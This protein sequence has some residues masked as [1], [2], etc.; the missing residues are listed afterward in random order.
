MSFS[1]SYWSLV[2][3]ARTSILALFLGLC[4]SSANADFSITDSL[5]ALPDGTFVFSS[6]ATTETFR[7]GLFLDQKMGNGTVHTSDQT[8]D[9]TTK[10]SDGF[11]KS[12]EGQ[13]VFEGTLQTAESGETL[14]FRETFVKTGAESATLTVSVHASKP[15][16]QKALCLNFLFGKEFR[17]RTFLFDGEPVVVP[18]KVD[19]PCLFFTPH[20]KGVS[21]IVI[22]GATQMLTL[23]GGAFDVLF[24]QY[25]NGQVSLRL[26]LVPAN[27]EVTDGELRVELSAAP[28]MTTPVDIRAAAN[29][30]FHDETA[31]DER[32][33]WTDQGPKNDLRVLPVGKRS[34]GNVPFNI[35]DASENSGRSCLVLGLNRQNLPKSAEIPL[36]GQKFSYLYLLHASAWTPRGTGILCGTVAVDYDDGS[37]Q[38]FDVQSGR[39]IGDWWD[40]VSGQNSA[41]VWKDKNAGGLTVGLYLSRFRVKE[42][43]ISRITLTPAGDSVWM[44][45]G[46]SGVKEGII[47]AMPND[48]DVP[49]TIVMREDDDWKSFT[50]EKDIVAGSALD[51][52]F[53]Q[54]APAGKYGPVIIKGGRFVFRDRPDQPVRF[55]GTN[56]NSEIVTGLTNEECEIIA[57]RI[58]ALGYNAIRLHHFDDTLIKEG[59]TQPEFDPKRLDRMDYLISCLKR[60]GIYLVTDL[61]IS[62]LKGFPEKYSDITEVK[63]SA[64]FIPEVR[65]NIKA[66]AKTLLE[67]VNPYTGLAL[68]DEPALATLSMI[69]EDALATHY[70]IDYLNRYPRLRKAFDESFAIWCA[71]K[72]VPVPDTPA[73]DPELLTR[74]LTDRQTALYADLSA[75]VRS[76]G[77]M[78][79]LTDMSH[80]AL[81]V[82]AIP[83]NTF[84]F[85]ENHGYHDHPEFTGTA[86][87]SDTIN[88]NKSVLGDLS[89][90]LRY[91]VPRIFGKPFMLT[92]WNF[93]YPN[94]YRSESGPV[95]GAYAALQDWDGIFRFEYSGMKVTA[96]GQTHTWSFNTVCDPLQLLSER[97]AALFFLRQDVR[98]AS[99]R[100]SFA[101]TPEVWKLPFTHDYLRWETLKNAWFPSNFA[102]LGTFAQIGSNLVTPEVTSIPAEAAVAFEDIKPLK[103]A[104]P[105]VP[106]QGDF[107]RGLEQAG[108][109]DAS[110][111]RPDQG[112]FASEG[113]QLFADAKQLSFRA[114]TALSECLVQA[115]PVQHGNALG[116]K[117][118]TT[119]S[120]VFAGS[121]DG[122]PL[123]DSRRVL[124]LHLTDLSNSEE[125]RSEIRGK[126]IFARGS[127][128]YPL[129]IRRGTAEISLKNRNSGTP[130]IWAIDVTGRRLQEVVFQVRDG[131]IVFV[132]T[133]AMSGIT[134]MAY[135][136]TWPA[137]AASQET[138]QSSL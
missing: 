21:Q 76:L 15:T 46:M 82:M 61:Y 40:P 128:K 136:I 34:F 112:T 67:H 41:V 126:L 45:A 91:G 122:Q 43:G 75:F 65:D 1:L 24:C 102:E 32:G 117:D 114:V 30:A 62:R 80:R 63:F 53:L 52:S 101:V 103:P 10:I 27:T 69:N 116:V 94:R 95:V 7:A 130:K 125:K 138:A 56:L 90:L 133:T 49:V 86:F 26:F 19:N 57:T 105:V 50:F 60:R 42:Q 20:G 115:G 73:K 107:L 71:E 99:T 12:S 59:A 29:R 93:C 35:L 5:R 108:I 97:I 72:N 74:F 121:L 135:E 98:P 96:F 77:A 100:I 113:G 33:G 124:V 8:A 83:R 137:P 109:I 14:L 58:A 54:D 6:P 111:I 28:Y 68:K 9:G 13:T 119:F 81:Y 129:L 79:P 127:S 37:R 66:Y 118:N 104:I 70:T 106:A 17:G 88:H 4:F 2:R 22:P 48:T 36:D 23:G 47:P 31:D 16:R 85:V 25:P 11:P 55:F 92:E 39:D 64:A 110:A 87:A 120:T 18:E 84:D 78:K 3:T 38:T 89:E 44:I 132:A 134:P 123:M 131:E 51:F